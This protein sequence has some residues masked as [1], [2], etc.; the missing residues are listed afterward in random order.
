[1]FKNSTDF[2]SAGRISS[3]GFKPITTVRNSQVNKKVLL[4]CP[5]SEIQVYNCPA[6]R[7]WPVGNNLYHSHQ[8]S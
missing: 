7:M 1:M 2:G 8:C 5:N 6:I 4:F 3:S